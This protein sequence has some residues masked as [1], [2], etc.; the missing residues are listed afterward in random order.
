MDLAIENNQS[1]TR[2]LFIDKG[3][4]MVN[5]QAYDMMIFKVMRKDQ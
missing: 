5:S 2:D 4:T 3:R 1:V